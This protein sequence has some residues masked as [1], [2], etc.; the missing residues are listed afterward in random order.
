MKIIFLIVLLFLNINAKE[1]DK[2]SLQLQW[3]DQYQF[4]GYYMAKE[5]G[6]YKDAGLDV[7]IKK[8]RSGINPLEEVISQRAT[9]GVGRSALIIDRSKGAKIV[10]LSAIYQSSP[11]VLIARK[12]SNIKNI[13]DM[14]SKRIMGSFNDTSVASIQAML[15]RHQIYQED[16]KI[17]PYTY[18][19]QDLIDKKVD[20]MTA[21]KTNQPFRL[22]ELGI[23]YDIFDPREYNFDVYSDLLFTSEVELK[24]NPQR[25][26]KF[27]DASLRGWEYAFNHIDETIKL[28][29]QK[30]NGQN[31]SYKALKYEALES[32]KL[33]YFKTKTVGKL[34][35]QKIH[36]IYDMYNVMGLVNDK[37]D[38]DTFIYHRD[39]HLHSILNKSEIQYLKNRDDI[40]LCVLPNAMPYSKIQGSKFIGMSAEY[41][42]LISQ[43]IDKKFTLVPTLTWLESMEYV[44][45]R[46][47]D[48]ILLAQETPSRKEYL[49]FSETVF[50]PSLVIVTDMNKLYIP[51]IKIFWINP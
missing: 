12:D 22:Q 36:R 45:N 25:T 32:K 6:F 29:M 9:Y 38:F 37:I 33:A 16:M 43:K 23:E 51:D 11:L 39:N 7:K 14:K 27:L 5:K 15:Q 28:I 21:Y 30:Y 50:S 47:C 49:N 2:I 42:K 4:A 17:L 34:E 24:K 46:E 8:F 10:L 35:L 19:L 31:K 13:Q 3:Q 44:K 26:E 48:I 1:L 41:I 20:L 40:K 18:S